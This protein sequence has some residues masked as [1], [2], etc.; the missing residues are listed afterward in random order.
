MIEYST[1][2]EKMWIGRENFLGE[3]FELSGRLCRGLAVKYESIWLIWDFELSRFTV[4]F[5]VFYILILDQFS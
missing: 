3:F 4:F 5:F 2:P 1:Y